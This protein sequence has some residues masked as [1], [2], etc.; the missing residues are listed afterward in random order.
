VQRLGRHVPV[1]IGEKDMSKRHALPRRPESGA[2]QQLGDVSM[3]LIW[4]FRH[5]HS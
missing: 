5:A 3:R 1:A 4:Q 2:S